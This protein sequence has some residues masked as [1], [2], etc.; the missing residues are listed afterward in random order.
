MRAARSVRI[1][2]PSRGRLQT[3]S[4]SAGL[5]LAAFAAVATLLLPG[6][7]VARPA[8]VTGGSV[9]TTGGVATSATS[10]S[11]RRTHRGEQGSATRSLTGAWATNG[12]DASSR[13]L[14]AVLIAAGHAGQTP[15]A[16]VAARQVVVGVVDEGA[17]AA[18]AVML[19][20]DRASIDPTMVAPG[21]AVGAA[22]AHPR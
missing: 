17:V 10:H 1:G 12:A 14:A 11:G 22:Q 7:A 13:V 15:A 9:A 5:A 19:S 6:P 2:D 21:A 3:L 20:V 18:V 4:R 16:A 8:N